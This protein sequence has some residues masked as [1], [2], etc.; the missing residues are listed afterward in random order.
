MTLTSDAKIKEKLTCGFKYDMRNS[1]N[2]TQPL[3]SRKFLSQ[4]YE[5]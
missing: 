4:V 3:K 5:V 2:F 1:M